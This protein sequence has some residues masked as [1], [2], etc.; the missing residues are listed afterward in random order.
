M[1]QNSSMILEQLNR[2]FGMEL[3]A[4]SS[5]Y[6]LYNDSIKMFQVLNKV[7]EKFKVE[8]GMFEMATCDVVGEF[9]EKI[10]ESKKEKIGV[11]EQC[12]LS[13]IQQ[14]YWLGREQEFYHG[15][16]S[17]HLY[18][19]VSHSFDLAKV[20]DIIRKLI[21][22]HAALRVIIRDE[23]QAIIEERVADQFKLENI[24][25]DADEKED[26]FKN[27]RY[28]SQVRNRDLEK[29]PLFT[30][31]NICV[32][33]NE[34]IFVIDVEMIIV[35][36][37]SLQIILKDF[38]RMYEDIYVEDKG[39]SY[40]DYI[41]MITDLKTIPKYE[42]DKEFWVEKLENI[43]PA[44]KLPVLNVVSKENKYHR[45][46]KKI[47]T[48][49]WIKLERR[50]KE[51]GVTVSILLFYLYLETLERWSEQDKFTVNVTLAK[52]PYSIKGIEN[53]VGE[54]TTNVLFDYDG[55]D[56]QVSIQD[57]LKNVRN[58]LYRYC[59]HDTYEGVEVIRE[60]IKK[61][62]VEQDNPF[63]I[64]YTSM[65][66]GEISEVPDTKIVYSQSQTSQVSLDN[67]IYKIERGCLIVWDYLS[68]IYPEDMIQ[69]MFQFY[70]DL[71][72]EISQSGDIQNYK[73]KYEV[74]IEKYND[75]EVPIGNISLRKTLKESFRKYGDMPA[76]LDDEVHMTYKEVGQ[77]I[78]GTVEQ[79]KK[80]GVREGKFVAVKVDKSKESV[81]TILSVM[82]AGAA[83]IPVERSW[84]QKRIDYILKNAKT[85]LLID[86]YEIFS[87]SGDIEMLSESPTKYEDTA[88]VIYTSGSTGE[89]KG[90]EISYGGMLNT[91]VAVNKLIG[92]GKGET[93]FSLATYAFDLSVFDIH[94]PLMRGACIRIVKEIRDTET[95]RKIMDS[96]CDMYWDSVPAALELYLDSLPDDY[97]NKEVKAFILSGDWIS[98]ES[99]P[100][101]RKYF[102]NAKIISGGGAT[103]GSIWSI[104]YEVKDID[105]SWT[106]IPY[107]Y[108][109]DNQTMYILNSRG[110]I[111]PHEVVGEIYI[112]GKGV[113][114]GYVNDE[115][116]TEKSFVNTRY[117]RLY[118][119]G[120]FGKMSAKGYMIFC[121]RKDSQVK[122]RGYR[123]ELMEIEAKINSI[124][125]IEES[126]A[127][128]NPNKQIIVFYKGGNVE[129]KQ[130]KSI[131]R[132]ALP[133]YMYP[134]KYFK[135]EEIPLTNNGKVDRKLLSTIS[136]TLE[137]KKT[138]YS[139]MNKQDDFLKQIVEIWK[140][141]LDCDEISPENEFFELG[142]DSIK[143]QRIARKIQK[144]FNIKVPFISII[145]SK[146]VYE[147]V[148]TIRK[149]RSIDVKKSDSV[150]EGPEI[151]ENKEYPVT[152][153]QFAYLNG[154]NSNYELGKYN[155]HYYFEVDTIYSAKAIEEA[156]RQL[157]NRHDVLRAIFV[158]NGKQKILQTVPEYDVKVYK[159][160]DEE[161][162]R[163]RY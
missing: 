107:G 75:T 82:F 27:I 123:I 132:D 40:T 79:L 37:M 8:L 129:E 143:A 54:F 78:S 148:D 11:S 161:K 32:G 98:V 76:L 135:V 109:L 115:E 1:E 2:L 47:S 97:T 137:N 138:I 83:Y 160:K 96:C 147:F 124:P 149:E 59:D 41:K 12:P 49:E 51:Y 113:A 128:V 114:K 15:K 154:K 144:Q 29:W 162:K 19:E 66:F 71:I 92:L 125:G 91:I 95:I 53:V 136:G 152:N 48:E 87:K 80:K 84:P 159:C 63:P 38:L 22:K 7:N 122:I 25:I 145:N 28:M 85:D 39:Q 56:T 141:I 151:L 65:L 117:G 18:I 101:I 156:L 16:N 68:K 99:V 146:S 150:L 126:V 158:K 81:I 120:D 44:P 69:E 70:C 17:T 9:L 35:D 50:A 102:P 77:A 34:N 142:G 121:G 43:P 64:V 60:L 110:R 55:S 23:K 133:T 57:R 3:N 103:E 140:E 89:P 163:K 111:C 33:N 86:P 104:S 6:E 155:A 67:Q 119:T 153:V 100:K 31:K 118:K 42:K 4:E 134:S 5:M 106:S 116:K 45:L 20:E 72:Q 14:S 46:Q 105:K 61:G 127:I 58:K 130:I 108:P 13:L 62:K 30:L 73:P 26:Y 139:N 52:R 94:A 93:V 112:G 24:V 131:I 88:Y 90:V 74:E 36:G 10:A 21:R 157:I